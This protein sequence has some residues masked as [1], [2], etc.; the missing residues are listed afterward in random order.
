MVFALFNIPVWLSWSGDLY[1]QHI[2]GLDQ[3]ELFFHEI[4]SS[5]L[6]QTENTS[7]QGTAL[8]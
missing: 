2:N 8:A 5:C 7:R 3:V 4:T 6:N 1:L